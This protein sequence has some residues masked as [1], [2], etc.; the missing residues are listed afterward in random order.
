[1]GVGNA[2]VDHVQ[3]AHALSSAASDPC[4]TF[5]LCMENYSRWRM[6]EKKKDHPS[7]REKGGLALVRGEE[8]LG[9]SVLKWAGSLTHEI[10][11][12]IGASRDQGKIARCG[13]D[14]PRRCA[15]GLP[16]V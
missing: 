3:A 10:P 9:R 2:W 12:R 7:Q 16:S 15:H 5:F 11:I 13:F 8:A 6:T 14:H 1:M 4:A